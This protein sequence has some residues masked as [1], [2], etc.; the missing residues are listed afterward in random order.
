MPSSLTTRQGETWDQLARRAWPDRV[1]PE[2]SMNALIQANP[3][4]REMTV[5][6]GGLDLTV[7]DVA[8]EAT[9]VNPPPWREAS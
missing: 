8:E 3:T 9:V 4:L 1:R 5:L 6:A 7:P 2:L